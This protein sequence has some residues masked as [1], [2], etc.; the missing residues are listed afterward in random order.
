MGEV[1]PHPPKSGNSFIEKVTERWAAKTM[2]QKGH[3]TRQS[4]CSGD[5][6]SLGSSRE[7]PQWFGLGQWTRT[8]HHVNLSAGWGPRLP[9]FLN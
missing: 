4:A 2:K 1:I 8:F 3:H 7:G 5:G 6:G 9:F